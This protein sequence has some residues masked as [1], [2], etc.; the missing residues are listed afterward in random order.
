MFG[1][2]SRDSL[3]DKYSYRP[4][5]PHWTPQEEED[6]VKPLILMAFPKWPKGIHKLI[7]EYAISHPGGILPRT[8]DYIFSLIERAKENDGAK[9]R[10]LKF[11]VELQFH[12]FHSTRGVHDLLGFDAPPRSP[13]SRRIRT[14]AVQ[15][16]YIHNATVL[17]VQTAN[18]AKSIL[19]RGL[20]MF[21]RYYTFNGSIFHVFNLLCSFNITVSSN[22]KIFRKGKFR[23][24]FLRSSNV[25]MQSIT[26]KVP[27]QSLHTVMNSLIDRKSFVPY[28]NASL[29]YI[30][31]EAL[32]GSDLTTFLTTVR[33]IEK[34]KN[35]RD[36]LE[37]SRKACKIWNTPSRS[38]IPSGNRAMQ[39]FRSAA[40]KVLGMIRHVKRLKKL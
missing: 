14:D 4:Y 1:R 12:S 19:R 10:N 2:H 37:F 26:P 35:L 31:K 27:L 29:T 22:G 32:G 24:V 23:L 21:S 17:S 40:L 16:P 3:L 11:R 6:K 25:C 38:R 36:S 34:N 8:I 7:A 15:G 30:L 20:D 28:R 9:D 5:A 18:E 39:R 33:P 13:H